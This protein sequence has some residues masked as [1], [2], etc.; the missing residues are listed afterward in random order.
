MEFTDVT[1]LSYLGASVCWLGL[2]LTSIHKSLGK[3]T[4]WALSV[5][6]AANTLW[7]FKMTSYLRAQHADPSELLII[8]VLRDCTWIFALLAML[9]GY[10]RSQLPGRIA[11]L[12]VGALA[13]ASITLG[14]YAIAGATRES[15]I[16]LLSWSGLLLS[17]LGLVSVEQLYRNMAPNRQDKLISLSVGALFVFDIGFHAYNLIFSGFNL[18]LVEA[19][20]AI[21]LVVALLIA[22]AI[23]KLPGRKISGPTLSLSRPITFYST[24]LTGAGILIVLLAM[25]GYY[26]QAYSGRWGTVVYS[27]MLFSALIAIAIVFASST[28]REYIRVTLN[29]HLFA[30]KYDYREE[31][32]KLIN[33]LSQPS[34]SK[35]APQRAV[36]AMQAITKSPGGAIW[37]MRGNQFVL[38]HQ[39][40]LQ[41]PH[42]QLQ[43]PNNTPFCQVM[44][45]QEW[46][47]IP[48]SLHDP[49]RNRHN[50]HIPSWMTTIRGLW[51]IVPL[52]VE[53]K[54]LGFVLLTKPKV[55]AS[56]SW[57]DR[58]L[59]KTV[60]R[61]L[62]YYLEHAHQHE[63]L[64]EAEQFD[65]FQKLSAFMMHD[66]KNL[67]AQQA[68]V[69]SNAEKHKHNPAFID[70]A[71]STIK[72][73]VDRMQL[74]LRKLR[75]N[76]PPNIRTF[77]VQELLQSAAQD[78]QAERPRPSLRFNGADAQITADWDQLQ[79]TFTNLLKNAQDATNAGGFIDV[80]LDV[81]KENTSITIEDN[82]K[83]MDEDFIKNRL[84][85][86]F[87]TTKSGKGMGIGVYLAHE[88]ISSLNGQLTVQSTPNEGSTFT[89]VLPTDPM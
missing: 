53:Q 32:L 25:G 83:G 61:Q 38:K 23:L 3:R 62:A 76:E 29:K 35:S 87:D 52:L 72:N 9:K 28:V 30:H 45:E 22:F 89:I 18:S 85:K 7:L 86:P 50:E 70:D 46:L 80:I 39:Q 88:Y 56:L 14:I 36:E 63:Q 57:E 79:M 34:D 68:L 20:A 60:G 37:L 66:L 1:Y 67:I 8:E 42:I 44:R 19:R 55:D 48:N 21:A 24:S 84:F 16:L 41:A 74:L 54:L 33:F 47:Y 2:L 59:L 51:L 75:F 31:W 65:T 49:S 26:V 27:F 4:H 5:A 17:V 69:V 78:C 40:A 73:S 82:G 81:N 71:M 77:S 15:Y 64:V 11:A 13:L 12:A 43:I 58:D 10:N 6:I